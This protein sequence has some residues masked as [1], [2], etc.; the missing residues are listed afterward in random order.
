MS[1][2]PLAEVVG[3]GYPRV[4]SVRDGDPVIITIRERGR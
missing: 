4:L 2:I 1:N 3:K